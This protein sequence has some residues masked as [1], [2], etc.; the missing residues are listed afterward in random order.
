MRSIAT[1]LAVFTIVIVAAACGG[2]RAAEAP[3]YKDEMPRP[4]EP[5]VR[6]L[7]E[8]GRHG[9]RFILSETNNPRTFNAMMATETSSTDVTDRLFGFLVD[10]DNATQQYGP[11]LAK[12][13]EVAPDGVTWTFHLRRGARFS[14]GQPITSADVLFSF[15]VLYDEK[16]HP[17]M[18]EMLQIEGRN[19]KVSA[20]DP[21]TVVIHT[22][23]PHAGL[24]DALCPGNLPIIPKH[25]LE[26][27]YKDGS[28]AAAYNVSTPPDKLVTS[29]AWRL[30]QYAANEKTVLVRN[31]YY[32]AFD[33][34]NQR[35][36]YLDE[37]VYLVT[38]DQ[39]AADLL[40]RS[41]GADGVDDVKPENYKWYEENQ[42]KGNFTLYDVG[43]AQNTHLMWFNLNKVQPPIAGT[44]PF[45]GKRIG[46]PFVDPVKYEWFNN[47]NFRRAVS[48]AIDRDAL[49]KGVFFGYG[50]KNWSH[51]T[52]SNKAWHSPDLIKWDY[53][54]AEAKKL[55]AGMG[56]RDATGDGMLEDARGNPVTFMLKTNSSNALRLSMAN[57]IRD[58]LAKIGI[59]MTL[60]PIDFNTLISNL[61]S[62]F[63]YEAIMLGFQSSVPP[64][65]FGGQNAW[66]SSGES[67]NWFIRQQKPATPQEAR[68]DQLLDEMLMTQDVHVQKARWKEIENIFNDQ[69]WFI[70]LPTQRVKL[71]VS[72]RFGNVQP[73]VMAHRIIWNIERVFVKPRPPARTSQAS[74][75]QT[76]S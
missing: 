41:G 4:E 35:L 71:P 7:P 56:L 33:Q 51:S 22:G 13:W 1:K 73:S 8:V 32:Y 75:R 10:F 64:T 19:F 28:F 53:N 9:G 65:P 11:G 46:E 48:M 45:H 69:A 67:H 23:K 63:Q 30:G 37:L 34:N 43:A 31:P 76:Q 74:A 24:L 52:S 25:A 50:E 14:D 12:S 6:Q 26:S 61:R 5:L 16:L 57:F 3:A 60:T 66:R 17:V 27:A 38:P 18:Q 62:D 54:P 70:W 49:I 29:G 36:P 21:Y 15:E 58:D 68:V 44:K 72:N 59:R 20:P 42:A 40:F 47:A 39:D 2:R 55:L